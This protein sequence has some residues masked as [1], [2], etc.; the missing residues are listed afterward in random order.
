MTAVRTHVRLEALGTYLFLAVRRPGALAAAV[1]LAERV[2]RDVDVTCSRFRADSD[3][4][5]VNRS[6]GRW[7]DVDPLLVSAVGVACEAAAVSGGLVHPL[8]GRALVQLGYD[9]DFRLLRPVAPATGLGTDDVP[10]APGTDAWRGIG[11]DPAGRCGCRPG[12]RSTWAPWAR[13]G[14]PTWS[15]PRSAWSSASRRWSAW[16]ATCGSRPPTANRGRSPSPSTPHGPAEEVVEAHRRGTRHLEH[17]G[18]AVE[19]PRRHPPPRPGPPD[20]SAR[21]RGLADRDRD[22][23]LVRGSEH[24]EHGSGGARTER[25]GLAR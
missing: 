17:P 23:P 12:R 8:L 24:G 3:L 25:T 1:R 9:R 13:P 6:P 22:R 5:R 14:Q 21:R 19:P 15:P 18:P 4:S 11:L 16:E 20:G 2:V 10:D 7:V